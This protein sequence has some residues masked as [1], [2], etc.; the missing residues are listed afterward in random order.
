MDL[1]HLEPSRHTFLTPLNGF[2]R[3]TIHI[4][5]VEEIQ[6]YFNVEHQHSTTNKRMNVEAINEQDYL[7]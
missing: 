6:V 2:L 5:H 3:G 7:K 4:L 1:G